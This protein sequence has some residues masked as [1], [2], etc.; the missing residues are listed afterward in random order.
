MA[1]QLVRERVAA[2]IGKFWKGDRDK[3][4]TGKVGRDC[5]YVLPRFN[6]QAKRYTAGLGIGAGSLPLRQRQDDLRL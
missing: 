4:E 2:P 3:R 1:A 6:E 5:S